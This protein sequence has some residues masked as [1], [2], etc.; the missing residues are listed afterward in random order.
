MSK[1]ETCLWGCFEL[2]EDTENTE[3]CEHY[4]DAT[5]TDV[6]DETYIE[7]MR[8]KFR[9]EWNVYLEDWNQLKI[10]NKGV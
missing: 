7:D 9:E 3:E 1:C 10:I 2:N 8:I 5:E 6:F 4:Y